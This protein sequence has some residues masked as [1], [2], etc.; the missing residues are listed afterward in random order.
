VG[1]IRD[2]STKPSGSHQGLGYAT[3]PAVVIEQQAGGGFA[4]ERGAL[5]PCPGLEEIGLRAGGDEG[6]PGRAVGV[7]GAAE[8]G[9]HP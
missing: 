4:G 8:N 1:D 6:V 5:A 7:V 3:D 2:L 9:R